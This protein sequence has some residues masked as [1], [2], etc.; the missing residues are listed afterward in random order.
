MK[1]PPL[2]RVYADRVDAMTLRERV[3]IFLAAAAVLVGWSYNAMVAPLLIERGNKLSQMRLQQEEMNSWNLQ[4]EVLA[5]AK[6]TNRLDDSRKATLA[7]MQR[8]IADFDARIAERRG[9]LVPPERM[10]AL[11]SEIVRRNPNVQ[12]GALVSLPATLIEG[13]QNQTGGQMYRHGMELSVSG[14]YLDIVSYLSD[15]E[16][17]PVKL[18]WGDIELSSEYP[19]TKLRISLFTYSP[20]KTWLSL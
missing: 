6:A 18:F 8:Q 17:M 1:L 16:Q 9:Q 20:E 5:R 14:S 7:E 2:L 10:G 3:L 15:L 4:L 11:L 19:V 12:L 13:M